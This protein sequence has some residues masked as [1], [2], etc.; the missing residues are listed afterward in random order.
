MD[1]G[2]EVYSGGTDTMITTRDIVT[3]LDVSCKVS[4]DNYCLNPNPAVSD[5]LTIEVVDVILHLPNAFRPSSSSGNNVFRPVTYS[6]MMPDFEM[7]I[8]DR[9]G[10][11]VFTTKDFR[12][13]WNGTIEG[14]N[15]PGGVYV[16]TIRFNTGDESNQIQTKPRR[17]S[18]TT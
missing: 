10:K 17:N 2:G 5:A 4:G 11:Q 16:W 9:W 7:S 3:T 18:I 1:I 6:T 12:E 8:Y 13:G 15:A 14:K